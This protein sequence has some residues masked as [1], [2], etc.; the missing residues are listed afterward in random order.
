MCAC[1]NMSNAIISCLLL[2]DSYLFIYRNF[3]SHLF[4]R[5]SPITIAIAY[6]VIKTVTPLL[7]FSAVTLLMVQLLFM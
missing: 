1:G 4:N 2:A 7:I 3:A 6:T 5:Q